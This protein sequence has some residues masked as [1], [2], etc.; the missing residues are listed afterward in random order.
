M[1]AMTTT[2]YEFALPWDASGDEDSRFKRILKRLLLLL[3]L[4]AVVF[5]WLPL[6]EIEREEKERVPPSLAKVL[7][8]Q[9][10]I[11]PPPPP[12]EPVKQ[13]EKTETVEKKAA[14]EPAPAKEVK[15]AREKVSKMGVAAFSK[16]LSSLRSSLD[17]AK[18]QA[19]NT[20]VKTGA[21]AK[22]ARSVLG[23]TSAT[24]TSGG[25][26]SSVMNDSGSGTQLAAHSSTSVDSP[27]GS[28]TGG[29]GS[30]S[31]GGGSHR[32]S[33]DGG[34]DMESIRRVFEQH[35]GAIY[36]L[37]NR[38]LRSDPGLKGKFVFHIVIEPDGSISSINL[39]DSQLEDQKLE[40]KLLA[41]IQMISFGPEDVAAT[42]VNYK[43]DFMPG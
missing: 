43:F 4:L 41:R 6:P 1:T 26:N 16:E 9:R 13:E 12:P 19:R 33:V 20:N 31:S 34:R 29:G 14:P 3:L 38:A 35:K 24:K 18:L 17:V 22:A 25:V 32:S 2:P 5:P 21:A 39:V 28:G 8:E 11:A 40:L 27:I 10:K 23:A 37:Y 30:G 15:K 42:P 36:A 7:I